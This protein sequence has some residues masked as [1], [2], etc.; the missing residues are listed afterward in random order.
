MDSNKR[1]VA[2]EAR[3]GIAEVCPVC[4]T[5][6]TD[7]AYTLPR[8]NLLVCP[9]CTH[10][11][12]QLK[13]EPEAYEA[14]YFLEANAEHWENPEEALF[15]DLDDLIQQY[16][17]RQR[18]EVRTLDVGTATGYLPRHFG[19]LG[20]ESCGVDISEDAVRY[21][22][23][24]LK[25]PR[26]QAANIETYVPETRFPVVTNIYVIEHVAD[27]V[28]FLEGIRRSLADDGIFICM[29]VDSDSLIFRM[30]K[31]LYRITGGRSFGPLERIC[32]VHHLNHFNR[33]SLEYALD[34]SGFE[35][36]HRFSRNLPLRTLTLQPLQR[37]AVAALYM[38]S[39]LLDSWFLQ[40]VVCRPKHTDH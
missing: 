32:E 33:K 27:P 38:L 13:V 30:A 7:I 4:G 25:I 10:L 21:G 24:E 18:T 39:P 22:T 17:P 28:P 3:A 36:V 14:D 34:K 8:F 2:P 37:V 5:Q 12:S 31:M 11:F 9:G 19:A 20:Y 1:G 35:V 29:T 6:C 23:E 15:N 16:V 40:G 26:L